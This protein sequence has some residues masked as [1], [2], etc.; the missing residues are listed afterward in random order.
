MTL[1]LSV[2]GINFNYGAKTALDDVSFTVAPGQFCA[3][4]GPNG[5]GKSTLISLL[6]RLLVAPEGDISI[7]GHDLRA[8]PRRAL[9]QLGVVFQQPTLD[10]NLT[11]RQ[12]MS[13][14][15]AL[16]GLP[17]AEVPGRI[18]QALDRLDMRARGD[19]KV[20]A[21]NGGHRRRMELARALLHEPAVLLLDEP[22]V[23]LDAAARQNITEHVHDLADQGLC[24]LWTTHLT[25][26]VRDSD[27]LLVLHK[28]KII[29]SGATGEIRG[30]R[31]LSDWFLAQTG[32]AA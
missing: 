11:V 3:L 6:T 17:R 18:D 26:E 23:G 5:A 9:A 32:A 4:L 12:N 16:H 30:E 20:H 19:E 7:A 13:Y 28:G 29:N 1:G 21:L 10:L 15:A 22:T 2:Q 27:A 24:V 31:P 14:F 8:T 25:D